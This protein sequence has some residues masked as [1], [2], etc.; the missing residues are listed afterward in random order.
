LAGER[1]ADRDSHHY[2]PRPVVGLDKVRNG[3]EYDEAK[4]DPQGCRGV[5]DYTNG[6]GSDNG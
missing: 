2:E 3:D 1:G 4:A 6:C 5:D